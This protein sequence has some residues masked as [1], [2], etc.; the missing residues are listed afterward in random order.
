MYVYVSY[1]LVLF[2]DACVRRICVL[3][4]LGRNPAREMVY[5]RSAC[6]HASQTFIQFK[7]IVPTALIRNLIPSF[8]VCC[9]N[10]RVCQAAEA[11]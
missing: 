10:L 9:A 5:A 4:G 2:R 3:Q 11:R 1:L 7:Q 6:V 8:L